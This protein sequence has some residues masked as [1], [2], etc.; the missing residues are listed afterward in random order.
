[1][2]HIDF[3]G[4][5]KY[6]FAF[7]I[8]LTIIGLL[9]NIFMGTK[10]DVMFVGGSLVTYSHTG[11][12]D[13]GKLESD[14]EGIVGMDISIS[15]NRTLATVE[16]D[17]Q[18]VSK[19][20][21]T[22]TFSGK[23]A[24]SPESFDGIEKLLTESYKENNFAFVES[25][26]V[27]SMIGA[28]FFAKSLYAVLLA[29]V[30]MN[31]YI[32]FR[33]RKIGGWSAGFFAIIALLHDVVIVYFSFVFFRMPLDDNFIAVVLAILGYSINDN[34]VIYDRIREN[35]RLLGTK[36]SYAELVNLSINQS[37]TR[38]ISITFAVFISLIVVTIVAWIYG[39]YS[40]ITFSLPMSVGVLFGAYSSIC[41]AGPM[42]VM[43]KESV[44]KRAV[45]KKEK[46]KAMAKN[47]GKAKKA[48]AK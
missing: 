24:V 22:I 44:E 39:L 14:I 21:I 26:S 7:S 32:A 29:F 36:V 20:S 47:K 34:I 45:A 12:I 8:G 3:I 33:F 4:K 31:I 25:K 6:F 42:W 48:K 15:E 38:S 23:E 11:E 18:Q 46:L 1:M 28:T 17:G 13:A 40:I 37:L 16:V 30:L 43:W 27:G 10:M 35:R 5:K 2:K 9:A 41:L 19:K